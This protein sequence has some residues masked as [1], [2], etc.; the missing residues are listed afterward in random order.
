MTFNL[1]PLY[2]PPPKTADKTKGGKTDPKAKDKSGKG[3]P[4][5]GGETTP[6]KASPASK[7]K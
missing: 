2:T 7:P 5:K 4:A 3:T 1:E 6:K